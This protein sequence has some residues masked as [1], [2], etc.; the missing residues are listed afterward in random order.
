MRAAWELYRERGA[1]AL[2][3]RS[4]GF[5]DMDIEQTMEMQ[6]RLLNEQLA[7]LN[8]SVLGRLLFGDARPANYAQLRE[9]IGL[10]S[11]EDYANTLGE[12]REDVLPAPT[13]AWTRTSGRTGGQPRWIPLSDSMYHAMAWPCI[14]LMIMSAA[15]ERGQVNLR[16]NERV[17]NM[18]A[19]PPYASG[20]IFRVVEETWPYRM[21]PDSSPESEALPFDVRMATAFR[22]AVSEGA[23][24]VTGL[25]AVLAGI[26]ESFADR[27]PPGSLLDRL[28][29]PRVVA[30]MGRA[31]ISAKLAGRRMLPR[32]VWNIRGIAVGGMDASLFRDKIRDYWGRYP[33]DLLASTEGAVVA[34]QGWDYTSMTPLTTLNFFEFVPEDELRKEQDNP[35]YRPETV[36]LDGLEP[37][38]NYELVLNNLHGNPLVRYRTGDIIRVT[39]LKNDNTGVALPQIVHYSRRTDLL[40]IGGFVRL[41]E[42]TIWRAIEQADVPYVDW[43]V[44]KEVEAGTP[45]LR[46]RM[47]PRSE[48]TVSEEEA[49]TRINRALGMVEPDWAD[50]ERMAGLHPLRITYLPTGS[51]DRYRARKVAEGADLAHLKPFHVNPPEQSLNTLLEVAGTREG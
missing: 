31:A 45:I 3:D 1:Q 51:F 38:T 28:K 47:E 29:Q 9:T 30:R 22:S 13:R 11:Y 48:S 16:G 10:T 39:G 5:L 24:F 25:S 2:W 21:F 41:T 18:L 26:G 36:L 44:R 19:P 37:G 33:L 49:A 4:L 12:R 35:G 27:K 34:M 6:H 15:D 40:E 42:S 17:L 46:L 14:G 50:M 20:T 7:L 23:D 8:E 43:T 32:D